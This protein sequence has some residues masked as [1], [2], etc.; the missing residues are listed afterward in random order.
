[1][2]RVA[3]D[4]LVIAVRD[5]GPGVAP[6]V[7][8]R[9]FDAFF[10]TKPGGNGLGLTITRSIVE[11]LGGTIRA[12]NRRDGGMEFE[13]ALPFQPGTAA[14][15]P[16]PAAVEPSPARQ[17]IVVIEDE[18]RL[19]RALESL[20]SEAHEVEL[21]GSCVAALER[22]TGPEPVDV[23]LC[24]LRMAGMTGT[25]LYDQVT[26]LR[27]ELADRFVFMSGGVQPLNVREVIE[28]SGAPLLAKPFDLDQV[29]DV[30]R[31]K[32]RS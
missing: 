31:R 19:G 13:V 8:A 6:A 5:N 11:Q 15:A 24:D 10:T 17:R 1:M 2:R 16:L 28:R 14:A 21:F 23:V 29:W 9:L 20:L 26:A 4:Q 25:E 22:L 7:L 18:E 12:A 27:P 32:L 3:A 30:L